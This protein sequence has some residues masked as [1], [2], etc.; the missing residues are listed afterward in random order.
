[1]DHADYPWDTVPAAVNKIFRSQ[2]WQ[3]QRQRQFRSLYPKSEREGLENW[4][5]LTPI[6]ADGDMG[7]GGLTHT[8]KLT[9]AF[10]EAGV[11][12]F[13]LDDLAIGMSC[14]NFSRM[15]QHVTHISK[16]LTQTL[17]SFSRHQKVHDWRRPDR[18]SHKRVS[19]P[20]DCSTHAD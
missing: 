6:V 3:D 11:A 16:K 2:Q 13:H 10:V 19:V 15:D 17:S 8:M 18:C 5:F 12:M 1:M 4:D 7:F 9:R 20:L 14:P